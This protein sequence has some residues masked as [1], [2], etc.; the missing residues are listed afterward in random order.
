MNALQCAA[1]SV[2]IVVALPAAAATAEAQ[3][4]AATRRTPF[5]HFGAKAV[6]P[7]RGDGATATIDF[8]SRADELV[9]RATFHFRYAYSPALAPGVSHIRLSL[10]DEAIGVL[11]IM[12]ESAGMTVAHDIDVDPRLIVGSNKL[13]MSL[14]AS[15][16]SAPG[17]PARPGHWAEVSGASELEIGVQTLTVADDLALLPEPFFDRRDH[18]R[19]TIPFVFAAQPSL[20]TLRAA[21]VVA[22]WFGQHAR[23]RG[24]R[25][26]AHL[27]VP[28]PGHAIAFAAN[29]ERPS[30]LAALPPARGPQLRIITN[31]SDSRSKLLLV[32]GRDGDDLKIA[33]D[34]LVLGEAA[35][36]GAAVQVKRVEDKGP[37]A[38][39]EA[40]RFVRLDR[41]INLGEL[42]D[43]PQQLQASGR[44]PELDPIHVDLRMPPDLATW[45]GPGVPLTLRLQ[46]TPPACAA[47][48]YLDVGLNDELL[49]VVPLRSAHEAITDARE[50]FIPSYRLR[51]RSQLQFGFRFAL[52]DEAGCR[53]QA[54]VVKA[55]VSADS[56]IDFSG[57]P[58][59]ARMPNLEHFAAA[60][61]P[62]TRY[63]DLSQTV[64]V[65]PEKPVTA[66]IEAMLGLLARMGETTGYPATRV[67]IA[68]PKDE[69]MLGGAD[70]L[71]I[72]A[73]PQ[74]ALLAKWA[75]SLPV[76]TTGHARR[77]SQPVS[78]ATAVYEWLGFSAPPDTA[79]ASQ[80]SFE[81]AGPL[82]AVYGFESPLTSGRSVVAI[83]AVA[84]DQMLRL[85]DALDNPEMRREVRGSA[86][87]VL[88]NKVQSVLV[89]RTY[90]VGFL[91]LWTGAGYWL[92][93]H[94]VVL[95]VLAAL[96]LLA[97]AYAM[98]R[99]QQKVA[100]WRVRS[101][102]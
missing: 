5:T 99:V 62:F 4:G 69:A 47:D 97:V 23:W 89:G 91:P 90:E 9:T 10:N 17:D 73:S 67:R 68:T 53:E 18:R 40:P 75:E 36:S 26:P 30:F 35:M 45:R 51:S 34:A 41:A 96:A 32:L 56:T 24:A 22:S 65:L 15:R 3:S 27:D 1:A 28:A 77:V 83:T 54:G 72:G 63:A 52:K 92:S 88:P 78:R 7:L 95:G 74:Q 82:A 8:G 50:L 12:P 25:F 38:A 31:P 60:G 39:Y 21:A 20:A 55:T 44:P 94:P 87:F 37:R 61:F 71:L 2:L 66:D 93:E 64:V 58:H 6:L 46:Y 57:F 79:I 98:W 76:A 49:Q 19:V 101:R 13:A 29:G 102:A 42:I 43:W 11:P 59:Y 100:A 85:L 16:G 84:P 70:L 81:G 14:V 80:V 86:A 48:S 33:T